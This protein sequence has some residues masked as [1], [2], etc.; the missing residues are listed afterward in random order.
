MWL[1]SHN[2]FFSKRNACKIATKFKNFLLKLLHITELEKH[3]PFHLK[4]YCFF[5][6]FLQPHNC[7]QPNK[8][9]IVTQPPKR[10]YCKHLFCVQTPTVYTLQFYSRILPTNKQTNNFLCKA[11]VC[12][13]R[14]TS[15][16]TR[17]SLTYA[18][19]FLHEFAF[20]QTFHIF[21]TF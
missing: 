8:K 3:N 2:L 16:L 18:I 19:K 5:F 9:I 20:G 11:A 17:N 12:L 10:F 14:N 6:F 21:T 4:A 15:T 7:Y 1:K 13:F